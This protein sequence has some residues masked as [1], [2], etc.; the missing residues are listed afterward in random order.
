MISKIE[1]RKIDT[2]KI[3]DKEIDNATKKLAEK[4]EIDKNKAKS[5]LG[6]GVIPG[7]IMNRYHIQEKMSNGNNKND[8]EI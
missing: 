3:Y 4:M 1:S 7:I 6:I 8:K 5:E 2:L